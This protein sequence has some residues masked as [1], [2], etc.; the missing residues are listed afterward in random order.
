MRRIAAVGAA[1]PEGHLQAV[2]P[3]RNRF[4]PRPLR[5]IHPA[6]RMRADRPAG[7]GTRARD[8]SHAGPVRI[9]VPSGRLLWKQGRRVRPN[10]EIEDVELSHFANDHPFQLD[11][12]PD[13]FRTSAT[14]DGAGESVDSP[15]LLLFGFAIRIPDRVLEN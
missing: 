11:R 2:I 15:A 1:S 6:V 3:E 5:D 8:L 10:R 7:K 12:R 13:L 9:P 4:R 14:K